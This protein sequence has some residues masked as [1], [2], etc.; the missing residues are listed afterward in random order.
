MGMK[1][2]V[3]VNET[4][5]IRVV[6]LNVTLITRGDDG[7]GRHDQHGGDGFIMRRHQLEVSK[8]IE[9]ESRREFFLFGLVCASDPSTE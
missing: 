4:A 2:L 3:L 8:G 5:F 1:R 7:F 9:L 6:N